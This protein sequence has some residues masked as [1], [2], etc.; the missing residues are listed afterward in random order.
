MALKEGD[1][2]LCLT[3][4]SAVRA[5]VDKTGLE[6]CS[7]GGIDDLVGGGGMWNNFFGDTGEGGVEV[8]EERGEREKR[9]RRETT[10]IDVEVKRDD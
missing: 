3:C 10:V 1:P 6:L 8:V 4:G 9:A 5:N 2:T 7:G